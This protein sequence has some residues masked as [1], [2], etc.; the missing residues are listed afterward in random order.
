ML[1]EDVGDDTVLLSVVDDDVVFFV[2]SLLVE[3]VALFVV[4]ELDVV[5]WLLVDVPLTIG[6]ELFDM[7]FWPCC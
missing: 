4:P 7:L 5:A 6:L 3:F 2:V 1:G